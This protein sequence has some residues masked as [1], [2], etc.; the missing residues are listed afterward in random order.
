VFHTKNDV[1]GEIVRYK[2]QLVAKG[3]FQVAGVDF[4]ETFAHVAR[5]I[6]VRCILALEAAMDWEIHQMD[7]KIV[8]L[9]RILGVK[10]YM[11]QPKSF[12]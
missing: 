6:I 1:L 7:V 11:N 3:Y 12:V 9:N 8:F 10:I 4:N 5:F 2:A